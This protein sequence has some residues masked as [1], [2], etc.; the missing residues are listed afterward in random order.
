VHVCTPP[1]QHAPAPRHGAYPAPEPRTSAQP[2]HRRPRGG[3]RARH[4]PP[5]TAAPRRTPTGSYP[6]TTRTQSHGP[7]E[8]RHAP[9][10]HRRTTT[11]NTRQ[12][13]ESGR[14]GTPVRHSFV[15]SISNFRSIVHVF[16]SAQGTNA[17]SSRSR[18]SPRRVSKDFHRFSLLP[19]FP[20]SLLGQASLS[21]TLRLVILC[22]RVFEARA[23]GVHHLAP[24]SVHPSY[25][26][27]FHRDLYLPNH[28]K[29]LRSI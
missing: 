8:R 4:R 20:I 6:P 25:V 12:E 22:L 7:G 27:R 3:E 14:G 13:A 29:L 19:L 2:G 11:E 18:R 23:L 21:T 15:R 17:E 1:R 5:A 26:Y 24:D 28:Q 10:V 9:L 16:F